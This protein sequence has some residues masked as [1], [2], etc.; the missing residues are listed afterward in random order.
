MLKAIKYL[1]YK[2][3][4]ALFKKKKRVDFFKRYL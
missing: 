4:N 3:F 1:K 2:A